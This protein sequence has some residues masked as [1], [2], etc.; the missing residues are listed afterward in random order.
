M[1]K[2]VFLGVLCAFF[3]F[4]LFGCSSI[5]LQTVQGVNG[6]IS[7]SLTIDGTDLNSNER[8]VIYDFTREYCEQLVTSYKN[9]MISLFSNLYNFEELGFSD[10]DSKLTHII[11]YNSNYNLL[12]GDIEFSLTKEQFIS[13]AG[14]IFT[15]SAGYVSIYAYMMFFCPNA[16]FYDNISNSVKFDSSTYSMLIDV[17]IFASDY[18][19][20]ES[21][22]MTT[23]L[24][25]CMP[26]SYNGSEPVLLEEYTTAN[27]NTYTAGTTLITAICEELSLNEAEA[28]FIFNFV[29]PFSRLH[30]NSTVLVENSGYHH[31]WTLGSD[32]NAEI[33][34]WRNYTNYTPWYALSL[35][36]GF[37][38]VT[39]GFLTIYLLRKMRHKKEK[40]ELKNIIDLKDKK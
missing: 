27:H 38:V 19:V 9:N 24:Q 39:F 40:E 32:I 17:P 20:E 31:T 37:L 25:T 2:K 35:L 22:F 3:T 30:S 7:S 33:T 8:S 16:F 28:D 29:T 26:F 34:L 23:Y 36:A 5:T 1:L 13:T 14:P 18:E 15:V 6:N 21:A 4:S 10:E 11:L 12:A